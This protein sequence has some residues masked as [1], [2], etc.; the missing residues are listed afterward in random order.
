MSH[1]RK[2]PEGWIPPSGRIALIVIALAATFGCATVDPARDNF[3]RN[4]TPR[5]TTN[6]TPYEDATALDKAGRNARDGL[7]GIVDNAVQGGLSVVLIAW[8]NGL[9]AQKLGTISG[10]V[11]GL[12]DDN[13]ISEHVFKGIVSRQFLRFGAGATGFVNTMSLLHERFGADAFEVKVFDEDEGRPKPSGL[14]Y[15]A[16]NKTFH[17][18]VYGRP[19]ALASLGAFV[20][21][22]FIIRPAGN[23]AMIFGW[24]GA[25]E[26]CDE[27]AFKWMEAAMR[28]NFY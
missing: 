5:W 3:R 4:F 12:I 24:R 11:I 7:L 23:F 9:A 16:A 18:R 25:H 1:R 22:D 19:S 17:T 15:I 14:D 20:A 6:E 21:G 27:F 13:E 26:A 2:M 10:D 28:L 8:T